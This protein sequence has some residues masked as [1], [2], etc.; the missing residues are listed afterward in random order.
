MKTIKLAFGLNQ[1]LKQN[2]PKIISLIGNLSLIVATLAM[3]PQLFQE[4]GWA[5]IPPII[6]TISNKAIS[7][8]IVIKTF[9]KLFGT[10][11]ATGTPVNTTLPSTINK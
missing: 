8:G 6:I 9:S 3:L 1:F 2:E 7:I 11:D 10:V 4:A 5:T